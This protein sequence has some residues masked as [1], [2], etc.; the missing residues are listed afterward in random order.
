MYY[1]ED[2]GTVRF[3]AGLLIGAVL[4]AS[5]ALLAAPQSGERTRRRL[6]RAAEGVRD[7]AADRWDSLTDDVQ[8]AVQA[9]RRRVR[10]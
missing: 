9:G 1:E 2:S 3:V 7:S 8:A 10:R 4:G 5:I 6:V